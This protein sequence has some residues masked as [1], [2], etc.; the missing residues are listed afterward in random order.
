MNLFNNIKSQVTDFEIDSRMVR[1]GSLFFALPGIKSD[2]HSFLQEAQRRGA[3]M[4]V[5]SQAFREQI[6]G[7]PLIH[8]ADVFKTL[9]VWARLYLLSLKTKVL[10]V[11]GSVG[12][13]TVVDFACQ[14]LAPYYYS[15]AKTRNSQIGMPLSILNLKGNEDFVIC[16]MGMDRPGQILNLVKIAPPEIALITKA[17][18]VHSAFFPKGLSQIIQA[19][20]E[21]F[22]APQTKIKIA[23]Y[24]LLKDFVSFSLI[25]PKA[26]YFLSPEN[27]IYE[28]GILQGTVFLP[29]EEDSFRENFLAAYALVRNVGLTFL[30]IA[31]HTKK[32]VTPKMRFEK[33]W[34]QDILFINDTYNAAEI[35]MLAALDNMPI[36]KKKG[37]KIAILGEMREL[38]SFAKAAHLN[39]LRKAEQKADVVLCLG[40]M[41][42]KAEV[43]GDLKSLTADL[44]K[45]LR[46]HDVVLIKGSRFWQM[47]RIL[48]LLNLKT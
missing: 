20:K 21:I 22:S 26:F 27:K 38:G 24:E 7:L 37:R 43:Y 5:V 3:K 32:L 44:Q 16:E 13:T 12:K 4:A 41:Y 15:V 30:Q 36:P 25:S 33:I 40:K 45:I 31:E 11:T 47:E 9:Q 35:S 17:A 19:K 2:G 10:A 28:K 46:P 8:V 14:M 6:P 29:F 1:P 39:V 23:N 18:L 34:R 42:P 48:D